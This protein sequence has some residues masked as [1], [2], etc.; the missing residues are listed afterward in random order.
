MAIAYCIADLAENYV[1]NASASI[2]RIIVT[3]AGGVM[4]EDAT[5]KSYSDRTRS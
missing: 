1:A 2:F 4:M 5:E 3:K